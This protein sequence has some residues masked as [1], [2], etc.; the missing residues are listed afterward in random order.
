MTITVDQKTDRYGTPD[1]APEVANQPMTANVQV[2]AGTVATL[3]SGYLVPSDSPL[4]T[5]VVCGIISK[6]ADNRTTAF[7]GG[8]TGAQTADID[9]GTFWLPYGTGADAFT[10][11]DAFVSSAFLING[12]TVGKTNV[13]GNSRPLVGVVKAVDTVNSFVAVTV[14]T[15]PAASF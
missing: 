15:A 14:V 10:Q 2:F 3:R 12:R 6:Y 9:R 8:A 7:S 11:A 13:G 4:S 5:D 1:Q